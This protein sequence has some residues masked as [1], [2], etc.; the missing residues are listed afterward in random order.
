MSVTLWQSHVARGKHVYSPVSQP[1]P[2]YDCFGCQHVEWKRRTCLETSQLLSVVAP[3]KTCWQNFLLRRR[4]LAFRLESHY[5]KLSYQL[6]VSNY[7]H[8]IIKEKTKCNCG[9]MLA[10]IANLLFPQHMVASHPR[11]QRQTTLKQR[12][13]DAM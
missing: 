12:V 7:L 9:N 3:Y 13:C 5:F 10:T 2:S 1:K 11:Q 8:R 6:A 4:A